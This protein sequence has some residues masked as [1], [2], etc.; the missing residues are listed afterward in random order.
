VKIVLDTN[1]LVSALLSPAGAPGQVVGLALAGTV[2]ILGDS[3][4]LAE[5]RDV[6]Y[7]PKFSLEAAIVEPMLEFLEAEAEQVLAEPDDADF[8]DEGDRAFYEVAVSGDAA[9]LV[10]GNKRHYST[11][12][13]VV[14]PKEF[15]QRY[16]RARGKDG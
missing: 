8:A 13:R 9:F 1:V 3:R 11:D 2:T 15:L 5:Y 6:L 10:T 12:A 4:I 16:R 14:S 7:R